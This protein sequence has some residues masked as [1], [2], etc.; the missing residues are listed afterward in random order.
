[1]RWLDRLK[2]NLRIYGISPEMATD[3]E[4]MCREK[5]HRE[6]ENI[7]CGLTKFK[8]G[9]LCRRTTSMI[10]LQMA[11]GTQTIAMMLLV[12]QFAPGCGGF[13]SITMQYYKYQVRLMLWS[14]IW[15]K[16]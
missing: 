14:I 16:C 1:M 6:M 5:L 12:L 8:E 3:R 2:K 15:R 9:T 10:A 11:D 7:S 13:W 4:C